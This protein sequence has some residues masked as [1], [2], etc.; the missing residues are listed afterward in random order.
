MPSN[1][2][3][4]CRPF[5]LLPSI[6]LSIRVFSSESVL[7]IRRPKDW[8][9]SFSISPS[10]EYSWLIDR[11]DLLMVQGTLKN[12]L[13]RCSSKASVLQ[14][15]ELDTTIL[16]YSQ[17]LSFAKIGHQAW[18]MDYCWK[19]ELPWASSFCSIQQ[20]LTITVFLSKCKLF[21]STTENLLWC[22]R[23]LLHVAWLQWLYG[24]LKFALLLALYIINFL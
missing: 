11:F 5:L 13:Q 1:Y 4:L 3:I 7:H 24:V 22:P 17:Q 6:F 14:H 2:L 19:Y 20:M 15:L 9:F 10:H 16:I 21:C 18:N 8:S 23:E 12:L